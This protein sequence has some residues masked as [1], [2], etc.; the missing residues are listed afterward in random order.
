M[1]KLA[2]HPEINQRLTLT[3]FG[4]RQ[5]QCACRCKNPGCTGDELEVREH[6]NVSLEDSNA[7]AHIFG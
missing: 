7:L 4:T 5:S 3:T 6:L 1:K 2:K